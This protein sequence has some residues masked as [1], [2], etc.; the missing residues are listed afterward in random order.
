MPYEDTCNWLFDYG[1]DDNKDDPL[2]YGLPDLCFINYPYFLEELS[3][4]MSLRGPRDS[5]RRPK[6][7]TQ[8]WRYSE[9]GL[10]KKKGYLNWR[11]LGGLLWI[12]G[13]AGSGKSTFMKHLLRKKEEEFRNTPNT[14]VAGFFFNGRGVEAERSAAS[15]F[16]ALLWQIFHKLRQI[17]DLILPEF[18]KK[19]DTGRTITWDIE[20]LKLIFE[21][22]R[23]CSEPCRIYIFVDALDEM[24][25]N[26]AFSAL[27]LILF[28]E[29]VASPRPSDCGIVLSICFSSRPIPSID[30]R[31]S[32]L[33]PV[34]QMQEENKDDITTYVRGILEPYKSTNAD[35]DLTIY[36]DRII[37]KAD[38]VFLW[39]S[40]VS[41]GLIE[42]I[43]FGTQ[44]ELENRLRD[45]PVELSGVYSR[46]LQDSDPKRKPELFQMVCLVLFAER[47]LSLED[48]RKALYVASAQVLQPH[49]S[50]R[51]T[52]NM[53][54]SDDM[55]AQRMQVFSQGL[56]EI[57][58]GFV[59]KRNSLTGEWTESMGNTVQVIHQ[60]AIDFFLNGD[61]FSILQPDIKGCV[62]QRGHDFMLSVCLDAIR[63]AS[64]TGRLNGEFGSFLQYAI[65]YWPHHAQRSSNKGQENLV[66]NFLSINRYYSDWM[67][68]RLKMRRPLNDIPLSHQS[69][70]CTAVQYDLFTCAHVLL[71]HY[72][73]DVN[74]SSDSSYFTAL[75]MAMYLNRE[76]IITLL[77]EHGAN[78][79]SPG[80]LYGFALQ[81]LACL[82][83]FEGV[84][85]L[86]SSGANIYQTGGF[87]GNALQAAVVGGDLGITRLLLD[88]NVDVN[89]TTGF[90]GTALH[91]AAYHGNLP[92][93]E[94]LLD[95]GAVF[96]VISNDQLNSCDKFLSHHFEFISE[97]RP[98]SSVR[99]K[100]SESPLSIA[101]AN[102]HYDIMGLLLRKCDGDLAKNHIRAAI[103]QA[104]QNDD[105][106]A[107]QLLEDHILALDGNSS[108][109]DGS[110][111]TAATEGQTSKLKFLIQR[112]PYNAIKGEIR[113]ALEAALA[114]DEIEAA[115]IL[116]DYQAC[117]Q[118]LE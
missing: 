29:K 53:I 33:Y 19:R 9:E 116:Q 56:L 44:E 76:R 81:T 26:A 88:K 89:A 111:Y 107:S 42:D 97:S 45:L 40:L 74:Y 38:G 23:T 77:F 1:D 17:F 54:L 58:R 32:Q 71:T 39:V 12:K 4:S 51:S 62:I 106:L 99:D 2:R 73:V 52:S 10:V 93:V 82:S 30:P 21:K 14:V 63:I 5:P 87:Y 102:G 60:S 55:M 78:P 105:F 27:S 84:M 25:T 94:L 104:L 90:Y 8:R 69:P 36:G 68:L 86:L 80:G 22:L 66:H 13:K 113:H 16:R 67:V 108:I 46:M 103:D 18:R 101:A 75:G 115:N 11:N 112:S 96:K 85:R 61:G 92:M 109:F 35:I 64:D 43:A 7:R 47:S 72:H 117:V 110:I 70:L 31:W 3:P 100:T 15:L 118:V 91:A 24:T 28:L 41:Q 98:A 79:S 59:A 49:E 20:D 65:Q 83:H 37:E 57:K 95:Y 114:A 50:G 48:L 34:F 6:I